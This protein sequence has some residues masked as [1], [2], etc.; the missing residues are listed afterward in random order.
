[1]GTF[2]HTTVQLQDKSKDYNCL[3]MLLHGDLLCCFIIFYIVVQ[4]RQASSLAPVVDLNT[5][6]SAGGYGGGGS[7]T[8]ASQDG[9][10]R[11]N[12]IT[13]KVIK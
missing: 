5:G 12:H 10:I 11:F 7:S 13:G 4:K 8:L 1:M 9:E 2:L 3:Y 6:G